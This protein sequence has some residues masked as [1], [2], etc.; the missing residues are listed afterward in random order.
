MELNFYSPRINC[1]LQ[2]CV[3][4]QCIH[5]INTLLT[6]SN[7]LTPSTQVMWD[8]GDAMKKLHQEEL[9]C[10][11]RADACEREVREDK[12]LRTKE[13]RRSKKEGTNYQTPVDQRAIEEGHLITLERFKVELEEL[14][15]KQDIVHCEQIEHI[16][17]VQLCLNLCICAYQPYTS[18][19]NTCAYFLSHNLIS[20]NSLHPNHI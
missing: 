9:V 20:L 3:F 17:E 15:R 4:I 10:R 2:V 6:R 19:L 13:L 12:K 1:T 8:K 16:Q 11:S 18:L 7:I 5:N 14:R